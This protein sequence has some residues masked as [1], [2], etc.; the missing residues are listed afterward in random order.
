MTR[1][2][3]QRL[4]FEKQ[5]DAIHQA[6]CIATKEGPDYTALLYQLGNF[7]VE[8]YLHKRY[9]YIYH[10]ISYPD[11]T[12]INGYREKSRINPDFLV[13]LT[14]LYR[15]LENTCRQLIGSTVSKVMYCE[16]EGTVIGTQPRFQTI[17]PGIDSVSLAVAISTTSDQT[18]EINWEK[19]SYQ[20]GAKGDMYQ[21]GLKSGQ[22]VANETGWA[23]KNV[24]D[25]GIWKDCIGK[26]IAD[27][28]LY[29]EE[30]AVAAEASRV[31]MAYHCPQ[32]IELL[33]STGRKI[34]VSVAALIDY[35]LLRVERGKNNL[36]VTA[37]ER[38]SLQTHMLPLSDI[39]QV[40][41]R[42]L[43]SP[44]A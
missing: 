1:K 33:F 9:R 2:D 41:L 44:V 12:H 34:F 25:T 10:V 22:A 13:N 20:F 21:L 23:I 42:R 37:N 40:G 39:Y 7:Y 30:V 27:I 38:I 32:A 14:V 17:Y 6:V 36:L 11:L 4:N 3:F 28:K 8:A 5:V 16:A 18:V 29:W 31:N 24:S 26:R 43:L 19:L 15:K 35:S